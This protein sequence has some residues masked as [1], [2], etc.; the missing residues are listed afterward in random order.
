MKK[1]TVKSHPNIALIKY[2]GKKDPELNI[3]SNP[4]LSF[5]LSKAHTILSVEKNSTSTEDI[6]HLN[7]DKIDLSKNKKLSK[8]IR[9]LKNYY[10]I[11]IPLFFESS[12][13]FPM[14]AGIASS[15]SAF[16]ALTC[17]FHAFKNG[18]QTLQ[19]DLENADK[20]KEIS[21]LSRLGSGSACRSIYPA[22]SYWEEEYAIPL[23]PLEHWPM[24]DS[25]VLFSEKPKAVSS[26]QGHLSAQTSPLF[27]QR[28]QTLPNRILQLK[29]SILD[30]NTLSFFQI[31][32]EEALEMIEIMKTSKDKICYLNQHS[33][34]FIENMLKIPYKNREFAFTFD[35]GANAHVI[36]PNNTLDQLKFYLK[37]WNLPEKIWSDCMGQA[38][39]VI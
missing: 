16:S 33:L 19:N 6:F 11:D 31:I 14:S 23:H 17:A 28:M 3:P 32:E 18:S 5:T 20:A 8:Q 35:A 13:N 9:L 22:W 10:Q 26:S 39:Q 37:K 30:K 34:K 36:S 7:N 38:P 29:Q 12:N 1:T 21:R 4:S 24:H 15:A 2:W 27:Q 25:I